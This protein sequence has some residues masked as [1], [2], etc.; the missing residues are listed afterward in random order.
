V[1]VCFGQ[2]RPSVP[3]ITALKGQIVTDFIVDHVLA[4]REEMW[5]VE[6]IPWKVFFD[7]LVCSK[8]N[9]VGCVLVS[10]EGLMVDISIR[11]EF[12]CTNN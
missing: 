9:G 1:G 2:V 3:T 12:A 6:V 7:G 11:L 4:D 5:L 10:P 8:G